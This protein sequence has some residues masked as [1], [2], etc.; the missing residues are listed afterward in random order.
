MY[1]V[2]TWGDSTDRFTVVRSVEDRLSIW[3]VDRPVPK[4]WHRT[5]YEGGHDAC[6]DAVDGL[7][8]SLDGPGC[9]DAAAC[10]HDRI[11]DVVAD[12]VRQYGNRVAV[13]DAHRCLTYEELDRESTRVAAGLRSSGVQPEAGVAIYLPRGTDV[14]VVMLGIL[15]AGAA[16]VP[17]DTRYPDV[18]RDL[19]IRN[20][21]AGLVIT[22]A[23]LREGLT[24][25]G[26]T[27]L[28]VS[29][30]QK[31]TGKLPAGGP[32]TGCQMACV[33]FTSGSSGVPKAI[34]LEQRNLVYFARN[35]ALPALTPADRVGHVSSLSFDAFTFE[36]WCTL[37]S[38][39]EIV[40]LPTMPDL[41]GSDLQRELRRHRVT[42]MLVPTMAVNHI[43][44][45]DRE[46]FAGLR[47]LCTGGDVILPAVCR[48]LLKSSF[49]G[50]FYNLYGPT[51]GTT[52]CT[53]YQVTTVDAEQAAIPI[54]SVLAS[55]RVYLLDR[56]RLPVPDGQVGELFIGG[57]G[58]ARG[59][60]GQRA[61]T[62]SRFLPDPFA[63]DGS[64]MYATGDLAR[65]GEDGL[66]EFLGR[67][68]D[69]VKIR[70]YR[71]EPRE[72]E[73]T[74]I[75]FP[76]VRDV[77]VV[78]S[79]EGDSK[80]LVALVVG[81]NLSLRELRAY[82]LEVMPDYMAPSAFTITAAIPANDHGK[83]DTTVLLSM[84]RDEI[85]RRRDA[86]RPRDALERYLAELWE[87]LLGVEQVG[88]RDDF[89][90]LGGNSLL[91]FRLRRRVSTDLRTMVTMEEILG[92]TVLADLAQMLRTRKDAL[93]P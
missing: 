24:A 88:V 81:D 51:E 11:L 14:F 69:Q 84:A 54:G 26:V 79:G 28:T 75:R 5:E 80:H 25:L 16:Y 78:V 2:P 48:E 38:G 21:G 76:G 60:L 1:D 22:T 70:G 29:E 23:E 90:S 31:E 34:V 10:P 15:K 64:R 92:V 77:A 3:P 83:R 93:L 47:I 61:M 9:A 55:A 30:L 44:Q 74:L 67:V 8:D 71:V 13:R 33:L 62:A 39:A 37:A 63:A 68:D 58:V 57:A 40:V 18:R 66:L 91:A 89:F 43:V 6:L 42:A 35:E 46:A 49:E 52:A 56:D 27:A 20:S 7:T 59:Y 17:I 65:R 36:A 86:L 87:E 50:T 72:I 12:A 85:R 19:M 41:V 53:I 4:G 82:A 32:V 45:E 73:R